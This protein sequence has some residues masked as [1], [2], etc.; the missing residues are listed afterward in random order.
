[1]NINFG[2]IFKSAV[3]GFVKGGPAGAL[4]EV[5]KSL[6]PQIASQFLSSGGTQGASSAAKTVANKVTG[7]PADTWNEVQSLGTNFIPRIDLNQSALG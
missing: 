1:M 2:S 7:N 5:G 3:L 4:A 6:L